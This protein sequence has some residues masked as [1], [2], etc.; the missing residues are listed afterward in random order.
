MKRKI[1][2]AFCYFFT[3][4]TLL[5][6]LP[7]YQGWTMVCSEEIGQDRSHQALT[8]V[9]Q[10]ITEKI[11]KKAEKVE[12]QCRAEDT[13]FVYDI[14]DTVL[15]L[16]SDSNIQGIRNSDQV[17]R[18]LHRQHVATLAL[19]ARPV[20]LPKGIQF[21]QEEGPSL[22]QQHKITQA[23]FDDKVN[24]ILLNVHGFTY[25]N[26]K[27][28]GIAPKKNNPLFSDDQAELFSLNPQESPD[29]TN[30]S[31]LENVMF[32]NKGVLLSASHPK[33]AVLMRFLELKNLKTRFKC[34]FYVDDNKSHIN[35]MNE[36]FAAVPS[37]QLYSYHLP[38][39]E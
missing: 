17:I 8:D 3:F 24:R 36:I 26:L 34:I 39:P 1:K 16:A 18:S 35:N 23:E 13:L 28:V 21:I 37:L 20:V 27:T 6:S 33:G 2:A 5:F 30:R 7:C 31:Y 19:T 10:A 12:E 29:Y 4:A 25:F 14:D 32:Y 38:S 22:L 15:K 11:T 9:L